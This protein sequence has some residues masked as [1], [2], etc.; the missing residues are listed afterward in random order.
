MEK[1]KKLIFSIFLIL[2]CLTTSNVYANTKVME[3]SKDFKKDTYI[4][5]GTKFDSGFALTAPR[6]IKAT[7][8]Q[9]ELNDRF[10]YDEEMS[11]KLFYFS[12]LT[13]EWYEIPDNGGKVIPVTEEE[14]EVLEE[15]LQIFYVN[16]DVKV[17]EFTPNIPVYGNKHEEFGVEYK[18]GKFYVP[19][20]ETYFAFTTENNKEAIVDTEVDYENDEID[21]GNFSIMGI[22]VIVRAY[23]YND[24]NNLDEAVYRNEFYLDDQ[25]KISIS[26]Q[27]EIYNSHDEYVV[28]EYVD[29]D[30]NP[31]DILNMTF[32]EGDV[33][34]QKLEKASFTNEGNNYLAKD[35]NEVMNSPYVNIKLLDNSFIEVNLEKYLLGVLASIY[36]DSIH[37]ETLKCI[38]HELCHV[39]C[40]SHNIYM[41][42]QEEEYLADWVSRYGRDL[43]R[44][45]DDI[46]FIVSKNR[47]S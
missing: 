38:A 44:I 3:N 11:L 17:F 5:G 41:S 33:V 47:V 29:K 22:N 6:A 32:S 8:N 1:I 35:L 46:M 9:F 45:L 34:F 21:Y 42:L 12:E 31:I 10:D 14:K 43:I 25:N 13:E 28:V 16:N 15:D 37:D 24:R 26:Y 39:F 27:D 4:I 23:D 30:G 20:I 2:I 40:F 7:K 18:D 19:A 36:N